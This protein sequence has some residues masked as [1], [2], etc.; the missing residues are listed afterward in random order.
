M[1]YWVSLRSYWSIHRGSCSRV[2]DDFETNP[3]WM[4]PYATRGAAIDA[5]QGRGEQPFEAGCCIRVDR[6]NE[7][8]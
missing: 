6:V 8:E 2:P 5:C 7:P 1:E 3:L 4:G